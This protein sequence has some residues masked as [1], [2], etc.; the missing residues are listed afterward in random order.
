[1][2]VSTPN[3][4][5]GRIQAVPGAVLSLPDD[6]NRSGLVDGALARPEDGDEAEH[7]PGEPDQEAAAQDQDRRSARRGAALVE[8]LGRRGHGARARG[9]GLVH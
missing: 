9:R 6:P 3:S 5:P 7:E 1:M 8:E 4:I 2:T